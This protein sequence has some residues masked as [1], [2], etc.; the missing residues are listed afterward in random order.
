[1]T[2][3][4]HKPLM[5]AW[6]SL[7]VLDSIDDTL[8]NAAGLYTLLGLDEDGAPW[9]GECDFLP[10]DNGKPRIVWHKLEQE[11]A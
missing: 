11:S 2:K 1:M 10:E 6:R 8:G 7:I 4:A 5:V 9:L 3:P